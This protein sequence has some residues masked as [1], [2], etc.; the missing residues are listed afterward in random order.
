MSESPNISRLRRMVEDETDDIIGE[1]ERDGGQV[2]VG[3]ATVDA[4]V[5]NIEK[6]NCWNRTK[7]FFTLDVIRPEEYAGIT[8]KLYVRNEGHWKYIP[9]S[10]K[11]YRLACVALGRRLRQRDRI[12]KSMFLKKVFRCRLRKVTP[13]KGATATEYTIV[14]EFLEKL[15]G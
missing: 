4:I 1:I 13:L 7:L 2:L 8:L 10:S 6:K 15:S 9:A 5:T 11:I 3:C 12:R 14:D